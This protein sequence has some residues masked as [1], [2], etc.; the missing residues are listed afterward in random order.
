VA[1]VQLT[2]PLCSIN[3][4]PTHVD[5]DLSVIG[6][7]LLVELRRNHD[8]KTRGLALVHRNEKEIL[9]SETEQG[10]FGWIVKIA[11]QGISVTLSSDGNTSILGGFRDNPWDRSAPLGLGATGAAWVFTRSGGVW[12]QQNK[13]VS[14]GV[15]ARA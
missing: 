7:A 8:A 9:V 6:S 10:R 4:L 12:T 13:L 14:T 1:I 5:N 11:R 15:V 2:G 3:W